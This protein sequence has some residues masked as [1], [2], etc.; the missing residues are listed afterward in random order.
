MA[1]GF[2][3]Q[4]QNH[5][6]TGHVVHSITVKQLVMY[7]VQQHKRPHCSKCIIVPV[8]LKFPAKFSGTIPGIIYICNTSLTSFT[9]VFPK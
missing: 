7:R 6:H 8:V 3:Q 2:Q 4:H 5:I 1:E 9:S